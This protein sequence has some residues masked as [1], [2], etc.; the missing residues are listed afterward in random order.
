MSLLEVKNIS[1]NYDS[2]SLAQLEN[3]SLE[4]APAQVVAM[5]GPSG[6][7]KT[8]LLRIIKGALL[9]QKGEVF[10][11]DDLLCSHSY[12]NETLIEKMSF[13]AQESSLDEELTVFE[14]IKAGFTRIEDDTRAINKVRDMIE[15]F[16]LEYKDHKLPEDLSAGQRQRVEFAKALV[17]DPSLLLLD[18]PFNNLDQFLKEDIISEIFP[19][20]KERNIAVVFVTHNLE[21]AYSISDQMLVLAHGKIQQAGGPKDIYEHPQS[22]F[23]AK[24]TGRINLVASNVVHSSENDVTVKNILGE[25]ELDRNS[26]LDGKKFVYL[27]IRPEN[28]EIA[29]DAPFV[30]RVKKVDYRGDKTYLEV[31]TQDKNNFLISVPGKSMYSINNQ[32]RFDIPREVSFLLSI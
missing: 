3:I 9:P 22:A 32:V 7:G 4:V 26:N 8:T 31:A 20:F 12:L 25:F 18:E 14:N 11:H 15:I 5:V 24:F 10:F 27:A 28:V 6:T 1:Y 21:E 16:G 19:I 29:A 30:G 13:V 2:K 23:V 17:K